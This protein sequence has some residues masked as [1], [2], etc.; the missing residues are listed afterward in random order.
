MHPAPLRRLVAGASATAI[1]AAAFL[2]PAAVAAADDLVEAAPAAEISEAT[3]DAPGSEDPNQTPGGGAAL[4]QPAEAAEEVAAEPI[5]EATA[6]DRV[7]PAADPAQQQLVPTASSTDDPQDPEG[8]IAPGATL[9]VPYPVSGAKMVYVHAVGDDLDVSVTAAG[10]WVY[11]PV[12][13]GVIHSGE[14]YWLGQQD[15][16]WTLHLTNTG[17]EPIAPEY[18]LSYST[19][20]TALGLTSSLNAPYLAIDVTPTID[21][22][23]RGDLQIESEVIAPDGSVSRQALQQRFPGSTQ[24]S[25][26]YDHLPTGRYFVRAWT[27][28][29][30][31]TYQ[32][33]RTVGVHEA[34]T[35]PPA[36]VVSTTPVTPN[37]AGWFAAPVTVTFTGSDSG[38]GYFATYYTVDGGAE[39]ALAASTASFPLTADGEHTVSFFG[40]DAQGNDSDVQS[41]TIR[42]DATDPIIALYGIVDGARYEVGEELFVEFQCGDATSGLVG[43]DCVSD[44]PDGARVDTTTPGEYTFTIEATDLAGN[45]TH[46]ERSYGVGPAPDSTDPVIAVD[47]AQV[48][49]SGWYLDEVTVR[50][51][52]SDESGI[53]RLHVEYDTESGRVVREVEA[54]TLEVTL[55]ET[56]LYTLD[57]WAEDLVGNRSEGEHV[58][59]AVD[60]DAPRIEVVSPVVVSILPNGHYAQNERVVI[61]VDC[62][63]V[64]SGIESCDASTPDGELLPTGTPGIHEL[65]IVA[66]DV[67]GHRTE[68]VV[69]YTVDAASTPVGGSVTGSGAPR[70]AST[71]ADG[72]VGSA[73][74]AVL[75]LGSGAALALRRRVRSR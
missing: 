49:A 71:G 33:T 30:G 31:V 40:R 39:Q 15:G 38:S 42:V 35:E 18:S 57:Y 8:E 60:A 47:L 72:L 34:E 55:D 68:R 62:T 51:T 48:P 52:A 32:V 45:V 13:N 23:Q 44:L 65:R 46:I 6:E 29:D 37:A 3:G 41:T 58:E 61:D 26:R 19:A 59:V 14:Y 22:V 5:T 16:T 20:T 27:V 70:L 64:G 63:D 2:V 7:E 53:R 66:T 21:G 1:L 4:Q 56:E 73:A 24:Y 67:A 75:L 17:T 28:I 11:T 36:V 9:D 25:A 69:S 10:G 50:F 43:G 74:L 12:T 54:D